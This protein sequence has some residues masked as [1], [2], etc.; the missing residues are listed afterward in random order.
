MLLKNEIEISKL[1]LEESDNENKQLKQQL[2]DAVWNE[3]QLVKQNHEYLAEIDRLKLEVANLKRLNGELSAIPSVQKAKSESESQNK[4]KSITKPPIKKLIDQHNDFNS[5]I[6][7][8]SSSQNKDA[9]SEKSERNINGEGS[10]EARIGNV[11]KSEVV[12]VE[13]AGSDTKTPF[14]KLIQND[15]IE[16]ETTK[17]IKTVSYFTHN[18]NFRKPMKRMKI[19]KL[20]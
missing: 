20:S 11:P 1:Q 14:K 10:P 12:L 8:S 17:R 7:F 9:P 13:D 3:D 4:N 15:E 6:D 5:N 16:T 19:F 2:T 18:Y